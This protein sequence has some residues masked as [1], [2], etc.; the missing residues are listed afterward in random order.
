MSVVL[1]A[2]FGVVGVIPLSQ[3]MKIVAAAGNE[4]T[5]AGWPVRF[6]AC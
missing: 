6:L 3:D 4:G 5:T 2:I 1:F